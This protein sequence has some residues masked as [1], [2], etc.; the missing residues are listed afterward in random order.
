MSGSLEEPVAA[1]EERVGMESGLRASVDRD[2]AAIG[3]RLSA[4][5]HL[6]QALAVTQAEH[7]EELAKVH[8]KLDH[9]ITPLETLIAREE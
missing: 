8:Q 2:V 3:Q 9:I 6:I 4:A 5:N 7:T 1:L